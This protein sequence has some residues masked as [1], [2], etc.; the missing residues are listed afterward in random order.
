MLKRR[1]A[2]LVAVAVAI[3]SIVFG[4]EEAKPAAGKQN[5]KAGASKP[6]TP[7]KPSTP[8]KPTTGPATAKPSTP[9]KPA[10]PAA[11]KATQEAL[12]KKFRATPD[13][14]VV[15][16]VGNEKITKGELKATL[17]DWASPLL[18]D[19]YMNYRLVMQAAKKKGVQ[20]TDADIQETI[21]TYPTREPLDVTLQRMKVPMARFRAGASIQAALKKMVEKEANLTDAEYA[22][23]ARASQL[24][25]KVPLNPQATPDDRTKAEQA[26]KEKIDKIASEIKGG[27]SFEQAVREYSEDAATKDKG[28]DMGWIRQGSGI[29][30]VSA[31]VFALKPGEVSEPVKTFWG[32]HLVKLVK[33]GK[34]AT[35][36]E[37]ADIKRM[38]L[39]QEMNMR[40][41]TLFNDLKKQTVVDNKLSPALPE[42]SMEEMMGGPSQPPVRPA[43][44][45]G[46]STTPPTPRAG[47]A[48]PAR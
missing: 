6:A 24:L 15:G 3:P 19:E 25:V 40:M 42:P 46:T 27:K 13:S 23:Y 43:P 29:Q 35:P 45:G 47:T 26:A 33:L 41:R 30:E 48:K 16:V 36:A 31:A 34:D 20:V 39:N 11:P 28:G 10:A 2:L 21:K 32:Y 14:T 12:M 9:A 18:L 8:A 4:I 38:V 7:A 22:Q 1:L 17:W 37:K 44:R 5:V